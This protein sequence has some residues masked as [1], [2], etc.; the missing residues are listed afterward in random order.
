MLSGGGFLFDTGAH[1]LNTV[2]DLAGEDVVA[3]R[4][5]AG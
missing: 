2:A 4:G 3:G 5:V 1:M